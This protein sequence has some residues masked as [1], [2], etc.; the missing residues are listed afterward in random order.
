[1]AQEAQR[2]PAREA[3]GVAAAPAGGGAIDAGHVEAAAARAGIDECGL[4]PEE[5][6][7]LELLLAAGRPLGLEALAVTLGIPAET[8]RAVHEPWLVEQGYVARGARGRMA[9]VKARSRFAA[10]RRARKRA[11]G[12]PSASPPLPRP[13]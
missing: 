1:V 4:R 11:T 10:A 5:R 3:E 6:R 13:G 7:I 8:V 2:A 9:T 12:R